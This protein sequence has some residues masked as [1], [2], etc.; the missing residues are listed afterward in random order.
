MRAA[1]LRRPRSLVW[2]LGANDGRYSRIAAEGSAYTIALDVD[3]GVVERLYRAL[4]QEDVRTILPLVGDIADPSPGLGWRGRERLPLAQRGDAGPRAR[5]GA[6]PSPDDQP[7]DPPAGA[8]RLVRRARQRARRRVPRPRRR[9]GQAAAL[10]GSA[11]ARIPTTTATTSKTVLRSRFAIVATR[12][13]FRPGRGALPRGSPADAA[14]V[15]PLA[16]RAPRRAVGYGVSQPVFSMLKGNPEFLVV[17][18]STRGDVVVFALLVALGVPLLV[19]GLERLA[20]V[21]HPA[22]G[23]RCTPSRSGAS[24]F[25]PGSKCS[26]LHPP[27]SKL[28]APPPVGDCNALRR[29]CT[30]VSAA[31]GRSFRSPSRS[32]SSRASAFWRRFRSPPTTRRAADV[33]VDNPVPV[34]LVVLDEFPLS[35]ILRPDGSIDAVRYPGFAA[36]P[37][38]H[39][40]SRRRPPSTTSRFRPFPRS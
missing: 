10:R 37:D 3:H 20:A 23:M 30:C 40:V 38:E 15:V 12:S 27:G 2:D 33:Q 17:R 19:L 14:P 32:R 39:L 36:L 24:R 35:S 31:S 21:F 6:R 34:V 5:P 26:R 25:S 1:V 13:S 28:R 8:R 22:I 18:A 9:D 4:A 16:V 29:F 7:H 11:R